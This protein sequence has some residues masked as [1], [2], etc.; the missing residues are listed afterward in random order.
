MLLGHKTHLLLRHDV[1]SLLGP[2][3]SEG[4]SLELFGGF[5]TRLLRISARIHA[6]QVEHPLSVVLARV[7]E[8]VALRRSFVLRRGTGGRES[9]LLLQEGSNTTLQ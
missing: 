2:L 1:L 8:Q 5:R 3:L 9:L 4:K 7:S 6:A